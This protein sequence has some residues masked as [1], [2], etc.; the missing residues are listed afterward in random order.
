[1]R[2]LEKRLAALEVKDYEWP[3]LAYSVKVLK[4]ESVEDACKREGIPSEVIGP[5]G[6][7]I[8]TL[9]ICTN[10]DEDVNQTN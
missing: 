10:E 3:R 5:N 6:Q 8:E 4:G 1:M 2:P 7:T 9:I